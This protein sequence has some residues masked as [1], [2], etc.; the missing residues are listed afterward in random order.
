LYEF[1]H[2]TFEENRMKKQSSSK[3]FN[4][5]RLEFSELSM[6]RTKPVLWQTFFE[7]HPHSLSSLLSFSARSETIK[8]VVDRA[9]PDVILYAHRGEGRARFG[10]LELT[11]LCGDPKTP[12]S[13]RTLHLLP[14]IE[15]ALD[16]CRDYVN[17]GEATLVHAD[18]N[19]ICLGYGLNVFL[20]AGMDKETCD[21]FDQEINE[22]RPLPQG[23]E[24]LSY[25]SIAELLS[26]KVPAQVVILYLNTST[27]AGDTTDILGKLGVFPKE[28]WDGEGCG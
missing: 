2:K 18:R 22:S 16:H 1:C 20:I 7:K 3:E 9:H 27:G 19:V 4:Q 5:M 28:D 15:V 6:K 21:A 23:A 26:A 13:Y 14:D 17:Q 8:P 11:W 12:Y 25:E 10:M 24:C